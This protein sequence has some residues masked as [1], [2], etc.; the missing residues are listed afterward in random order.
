MAYWELVCLDC[1][2]VCC[3]YLPTYF[4]PN[5]PQTLSLKDRT[6]FTLHEPD[7][8]LAIPPNLGGPSTCE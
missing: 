3:F 7:N 8:R 5:F 2:L 6:S 4:G 1:C